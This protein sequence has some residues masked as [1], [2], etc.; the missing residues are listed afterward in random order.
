MPKKK[1]RIRPNAEY[2]LPEKGQAPKCSKY[3][4]GLDPGSRNFGIAAVGLR[5]D[6]PVVAASAVLTNPVNDLV[7]F[8]GCRTLFLAEIDRWVSTFEPVAI[9]AERFQMRGVSGGP[10]IEQVSAM[11]GLVAGRYPDIPVKL[12]IASAWKNKVQRRFEIDLR[13]DVYPSSRAPA[14][15]IDASLIGVF[16]LEAGIGTD[17]SYTPDNIV[18]QVESTSLT[19]IKP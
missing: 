13:E 16:G 1:R 6:T 9:V 4:L 14:H 3:V 7:S 11:L 18:E 2:V 10:L 5:G 17:L 12:T 15:Q 8:N 19:K